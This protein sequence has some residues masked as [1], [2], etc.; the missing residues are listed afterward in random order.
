VRIARRYYD[1]TAA[2]THYL[3]AQDLRPVARNFTTG[4]NTAFRFEGAPVSA[5]PAAGAVWL[6]VAQ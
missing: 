1:H 3:H 2:F 4:I 5:V 6:N